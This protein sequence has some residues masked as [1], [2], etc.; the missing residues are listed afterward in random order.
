MT[1]SGTAGHGDELA[2]HVDLAALGAVVVKSLSAEPWPGNPPPR[3]HE[4]PGRDAQL[5]RPAGPGRGR[6]AGRRA[7]R[8]CS[9]PGATVVASIWGRTVD[10]YR[11]AAGRCWPAR[12]TQVVAV[13][14]NLSCPNLDHGPPARRC[15]PSAPPTPPR[16]IG[17]LRGGRSTAV[18]QADP[19]GDRPGRGGRRRRR[20]RGR[21]R[22][23][24]Q[25]GARPG[26]RP[27]D[28]AAR[29]WAAVGGG[30][31]GPA[32]HPVAVRAVHDVPPC[33]ARAARSSGSG[34]VTGA[35]DAVELLLA[36]ASAV[37]V[38]TATFADPRAPRPDRRA[39]SD[40]W[41]RATAS[42][43]VTDLIGAAHAR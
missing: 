24:D 9:P 3:V 26:H 31:S 32:I 6:V 14:V 13:E 29:A 16:S 43:A 18:G 42:L 1:A 23:A 8:R 5:G 15:S 7:A 34:G 11:R 17:R 41:C 12:R 27:R 35:A 28:R 2:R 40:R 38:G 20:R 10:E 19:G 4:T 22:D 25:H 21:G 36:G 33:P 39:T 37:Q 30:L